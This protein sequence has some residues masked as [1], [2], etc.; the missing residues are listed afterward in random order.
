M[1]FTHPGLCP[2]NVNECIHIYHSVLAIYISDRQLYQLSLENIFRHCNK[3]RFPLSNMN[4]IFKYH[5]CG[6][7][8]TAWLHCIAETINYFENIDWGRTLVM[9]KAIKCSNNVMVF[10]SLTEG[11][12]LSLFMIDHLTA[13]NT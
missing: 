2:W 6:F 4:I 9:I 12:K 1:V 10:F 5:A 7:Q 8:I 13:T 11:V 3:W